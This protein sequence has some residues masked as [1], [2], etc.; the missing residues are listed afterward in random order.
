M[1]GGF[2]NWTSPSLSTPNINEASSK[3]IAASLHKNVLSWGVWRG[4]EQK[5]SVFL[6]AIAHSAYSQT[7]DRG[8]YSGVSSLSR[9]ASVPDVLGRS[10]KT[11]FS[12]ITIASRKVLR[13]FSTSRET[14]CPS[15]Q[16]QPLRVFSAHNEN[17][18]TGILPT[19]RMRVPESQPD[20]SRQNSTIVTSN[21]FRQAYSPA[22]RLAV[23]DWGKRKAQ[24]VQHRQSHT[25]SNRKEDVMGCS[26]IDLSSKP[27][28]RSCVHLEVP[29]RSS[30][31][32]L[33]LDKSL[34]ISLV[35]LEERRASQPTLFRSTFSIRLSGSSCRRYATKSKVAKTNLGYRRPRSAKLDGYKCNS[36][37]S[38][39]G[40]CRGSL[41]KLRGD[42]VVKIAPACGVK[43]EVDGSDTQCLSATSGIL[44]F[45]GPDR[46]NT[47]TAR[48][49][50]NADEA[51]FPVRT[52]SRHKKHTF[53]TRSVDSRTW[54]KQTRSDETKERQ[55]QDSSTEPPN[56][57]ISEKTFSSSE[58]DSLEEM[59]QTLSLKEAL[60]LFRPDFISRSQGR[61]K[62][63]E[64]RAMRRRALQESNPDLVLDL[65]EEGCRQRRKCTTPDPLSDNLF[66][67]RERSISG[68]EMQ[69]RSRRIYNKLP[70]V[71]K[72]K[73]EE[74]KRA[75]SQSNRVRAEVFKKKL[76]DQILQR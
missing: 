19:S 63:L 38:N 31:S 75:V 35:G 52:D 57:F 33:F 67:P 66:K 12:S 8:S 16:R 40:H 11:A 55:D 41:P 69:L 43:V 25:E 34:C 53:N 47:K 1:S 32:V 50:G 21:N 65:R 60:E 70:E 71:T 51:A 28:Y 36:Q 14:L 15:S 13:S 68:R 20:L 46:S 64:K 23:R 18:G 4:P 39:L 27:S 6:R 45:R 62:R 22:D 48:Q 9:S 37:E 17:F 59:P 61:L 26:L 73:E 29:L 54:S 5:E 42:K 49:K 10:P 44:S 56:V 72:K 7:A 24:L 3:D 58:A 74:K 2:R 30:S 76:L